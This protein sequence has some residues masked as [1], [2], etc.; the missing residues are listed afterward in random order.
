MRGVVWMERDHLGESSDVT[1]KCEVKWIVHL[2]IGS[3]LAEEENGTEETKGGLHC[4][5]G[6]HGW[7]GPGPVGGIEGLCGTWGQ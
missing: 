2:L 3:C 5:D 6:W 7:R 1:G 4:Q